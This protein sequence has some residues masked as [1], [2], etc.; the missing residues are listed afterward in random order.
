[1]KTLKQLLKAK[2]N[3]SSY[4]IAQLSF[5]FR[6]LSS[7]TSKMFI[8]AIIFYKELPL[9]IFTL[10]TMLILRC[11][12]GGLHFYTY[13]G[14][15]LTSILYIGISIWFLPNV[16]IPPNVKILFLLLCIIICNYIGP[17]P[18]KYRPPYSKEHVKTYKT[19]VS[20]FIFIFTLILYIIPESQFSTI[21]FWIIILHSLQ[22]ILAKY[23]RKE[24]IK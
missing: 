2:Y 18:S 13:I 23:R 3:L 12:T 11:T 7:E 20:I 1:M 14:C 19:V 16:I 24:V 8:M 21:G 9:Y 10:L 5:L 17:V 6:T 22:L 15:L 4:Q